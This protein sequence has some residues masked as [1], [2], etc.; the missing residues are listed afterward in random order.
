MELIWIDLLKAFKLVP[1]LT[2]AQK[3]FGCGAN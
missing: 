1:Q 2:L 3:E